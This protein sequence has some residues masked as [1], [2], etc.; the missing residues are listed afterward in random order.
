MVAIP[1]N[2]AGHVDLVPWCPAGSPGHRR[3]SSGVRRGL[4]EEDS[5]IAH[6]AVL[7]CDPGVEELVHDENAHPIAQIEEVWAGRIVGRADGVHSDLLELGNPPLHGPRRRAEPEPVVVLM[8]AD[9]FELVILAIDVQ[10]R[11]AVVHQT[12][13]PERGDVIVDRLAAHL[14]VGQQLIH[15][16]S[17]G[18]PQLGIRDG[19]IEREVGRCARSD[20]LGSRSDGGDRRPAGVADSALHAHALRRRARIDHRGCD[21]DG[22]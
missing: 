6:I 11:R 12:P 10:P 17:I 8:Q 7:V 18:G 9:A 13:D 16:G 2:D 4:V 15:V 14:D 19:N 3:H 1:R 20:G 5:V 22:P 21:F